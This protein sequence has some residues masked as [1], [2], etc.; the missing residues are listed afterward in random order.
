MK[1]VL[2]VSAN[3]G[4]DGK[5][6]VVKQTGAMVDFLF[7]N[8]RN[9]P[10]RN[11]SFTP[12]MNAKIPKMLAWKI[13]PGYDYYLWIDSYFNIHHSDTI[14]WFLEQIG[15]HDILLFKHQQRSSIKDEARFMAEKRDAGDSYIIQRIKGEPVV[16]Q[17]MFYSSDENFKDDLLIAASAFFY[18]SNLIQNKDYNLLKEWYFETCFFSIRDQ[19]SL[20][21]LLWKFKTDY[22]L[23]NEDVFSCK[24]LK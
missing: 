7:I 8:K 18:S 17:A 11:A 9:W 24:Y 19:I 21:Y 1:K 10:D 5:N 13:K 12:R 22:K 3:L 14:S 23:L 2:V 16:N 15:D 4:R 20:P 6:T